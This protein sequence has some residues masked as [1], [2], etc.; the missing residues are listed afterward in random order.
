VPRLRRRCRCP[1]STVGAVLRRVGLGHL[2]SLEPEEPPNRYERR[3]PGEFIHIDVKKLARIKRPG[4][5][6]HGDRSR[7]AYGAGWE[8]VHVCVDDATRVAFVEVPA[9]SILALQPRADRH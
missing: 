5:R 6:V 8:F 7:R 2:R 1:L 3:H 9:R 4:H